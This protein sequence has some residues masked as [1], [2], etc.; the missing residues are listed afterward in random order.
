MSESFVIVL[1]KPLGPDDLATTVADLIPPGMRVDVRQNIADLP[2]EPGAVWATVSDT[3]DPLWPCVLN[4][5]VFRPECGLWPY[6]DLRI[7]AQLWE[8]FGTDALC[9]TYAFV[10][11]LDPHDP[12]WSLACVGGQWYLA[13]TDGTRLMGPYT[14]GTRDFPGDE[15]IRLVRPVVVPE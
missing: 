11:E 8:R 10:G 9:G 12:Y 7:A 2:E 14:D 15:A 4:V 6:P 3:H 5:H 1:S 13:S